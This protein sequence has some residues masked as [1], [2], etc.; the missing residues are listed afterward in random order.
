MEERLQK[1][2]SARGV[3]SRR[4]A[5]EYIEAGLVL[6]NGVVAT[7]GQKADPEK[8]IVEVKGEVMEARKHLQYLLFYKPVGVITSNADREGADKKKDKEEAAD[9]GAAPDEL[10]QGFEV[11]KTALDRLRQREAHREAQRRP[12]ANAVI[13]RDLLPEELQGK[14][15]PVGRLDKDSEGLLLLT[16]DGAIAYRLTHPS[17]EHEKE[18]EVETDIEM[19]P[20]MLRKL[21]QGVILD[22]VRTKPAKI[23]EIDPYRF[24]I[25][26]TEGRNRQI[27]RMCSKV[28]ALVTSLR[29]VRIVTLEDD[30]LKPGQMRPLTTQERDTLLKAVGM[31]PPEA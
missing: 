14:V 1:I 6:V 27:R 4:K 16:N 31:E 19:K 23:K 30:T 28:G 29:R 7:L 15:F 2:L 24:R 9:D 20:G 10:P 11:T 12:E 26:L 3:C 5:E 13:V 22:D 17:F 21:E 18:Y 8:D 25:T